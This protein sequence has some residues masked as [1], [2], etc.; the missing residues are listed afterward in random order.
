MKRFFILALTI[1]L[2]LTGFSQVA[3]YGYTATSSPW[4]VNTSATT[5]IVNGQDDLLSA[6]TNIGFTFTYNSVAY[7]QFKASTNGF[8]TFNTANT[9]T[10]PTNNLKTSSERVI[11][12]V[13]W[14]DNKTG[15]SGTVNYKLTGTSPNRVLTIEWLNYRWE[16]YAFSA[17]VI[18]C[19]IQLYETTNVIKYNYY[20]GSSASGTG[21]YTFQNSSASVAF[22][23]SIGLGGATSGDFL[24]LND[25][26][27]SPYPTKS[28]TVET[29]TIGKSP[30]DF[31]AGSMD[32][33]MVTTYIAPNVSPNDATTYVFYPPVA[34]D[35]CSGGTSL[36]VNDGTDC[37]TTSS[38]TTV[39]A[40]ESIAACVGNADDDVW[41]KFV[42][43][44]PVHSLTE[45]PVTI[46]DAVMQVYS[47]SCASLTTIACVNAAT[48][49]NETSILTG[50]TIGST[51]YVRVHSFA[52]GSGQGTFTMCVT[53]PPTIITSGTLTS[54]SSC[55][56]S[57]SS[58]QSYTVY[59]SG[60]QTNVISISTPTGFEISK[61]S[62]GT[63]NTSTSIT[64]STGVVNTT[65]IY[66][67][68]AA[69]ATGS[70]SGNITNSSLNATTQ[71]IVVSGSVSSVSVG[72]TVSSNQNVNSGNSPNNISLTGNNGS[73][74]KWVSSPDNL[75]T[76]TTD[77]LVTNTTLLSGDMGPITST[78]YYRAIV[79]NGVCSQV[80]SNYVTMTIVTALPIELLYFKGEVS[81]R[82]NHLTW[83]TASEHNN[84]Y[85]EIEKTKDGVVFY[86]IIKMD[87]SGNSQTK[88]DYEFD[89]YNIDNNISYY[90]LKQVDF[91]GK[92]RYSDII[93][94]DNRIKLKIVSRMVSL[95]GTE[96]NEMYRGVVIVEYTDG[97][98]EKIIR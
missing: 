19:Q 73:V 50:L 64:P 30:T 23:A 88:I 22:G 12:A 21:A 80:N 83:L 40:T 51:Y 10:Q 11:L 5:I 76:T 53:T 61:V 2:S 25:L 70:P 36:T 72:G 77:I 17:G 8:I 39:G 15:S 45:T 4:V 43:T 63:F 38:G 32:K 41:Y 86:S 59:G 29:T 7:T 9:S 14:D 67:R 92:F 42:A 57:V 54:F 97:S 69:N 56:G 93:S 60:L 62:G 31:S 87:G 90:R 26:K 78:T 58:E 49:G 1:L 34:N 98:I 16:K 85:F 75:F 6:V 52:S 82:Y 91:D 84:N 27:T 81:E 94:I 33:Y 48:T 28:T 37:S 46:G 55:T 68:L 18:N 89:D 74:V 47:G 66:V 79:K 20:R 96:V 44:Q 71:N 13:L 24:S 35:N 65:T 95:M 3:N